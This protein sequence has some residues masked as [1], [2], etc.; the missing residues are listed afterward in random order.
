[1]RRNLAVFLVIAIALLLL[2]NSARARVVFSD[3][4]EY[5]V[6]RSDPNAAQVFVQNGW[7][8][9]KTQQNSSGASGYL[10]T[11]TSIPGLY[12]PVSWHE[13]I[14]VVY[15]RWRL[16]HRPWGPN[17]LLSPVGWKQCRLRGLHSWRCV[18]P[19]LQ[20][21]PQFRQ[22]DLRLRL[23][24]KVPVCV[25]HRLPV[26]QPSVGMIHSGS[27]SYDPDNMW[28]LGDPS[29]GEFLW[30][31]RQSAGVSNIVNSLGDPYAQGNIGSPNHTEWMRPN[32][33]TLV[34]MHFN[35]THT[36]GNSWEVW[37]RPQNGNW[38]KV[39]E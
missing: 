31:L 3:R 27:V 23:T 19:V 14:S 26:P 24:R 8:H 28:P 20:Y 30:A 34:K 39:S 9:A 25:Q 21:P 37:L 4:F 12:R 16:C 35:T 11:V 2:E 10:H 6:G 1:M 36:T 5:A 22:P 38:T 15:R 7:S 32:R 29:R 18:V 17:R 33:W 13:L